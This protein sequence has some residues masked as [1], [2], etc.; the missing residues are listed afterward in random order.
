MKIGHI[1][2]DYHMTLKEQLESIA[3][4]YIGFQYICVSCRRIHF[5][6]ESEVSK[7]ESV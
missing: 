2:R 4:D 3:E 1:E 5:M 7:N 6:Y